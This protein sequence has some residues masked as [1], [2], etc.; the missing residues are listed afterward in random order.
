[1]ISTKIRNVLQT[2]H[3]TVDNKLVISKQLIEKLTKTIKLGSPTNKTLREKIQ[4]KIIK[5]SKRHLTKFQILL[6]TKGPKFCPTTKGNVF[7]IK[8]DFKELT[9]KLKLRERFWGIEYDDEILV[10]SKSNINVN[11][12]IPEFSNISNILEQVEPTINNVND[13]LTKQERRALKEL[14]EDQDLVT[15][16]TGSHQIFT[17]CQRYI[18]LILHKII[19]E[20]N[21]SNNIF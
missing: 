7:D 20:I 8:S 16:K 10:K 17:Y 2:R 15:K 21:E 1:M 3:A 5:L 13:N 9:R 14:E 19:E 11:T 12:S 6:L 18:S 4:P